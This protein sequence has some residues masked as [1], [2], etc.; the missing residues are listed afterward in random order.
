MGKLQNNPSIGWVHPKSTHVHPLGWGNKNIC[1]TFGV[2]E[3]LVSRVELDNI[4]WI[5][6]ILIYSSQHNL[7]KYY[8]E[9]V[10]SF[11]C[12]GPWWSMSKSITNNDYN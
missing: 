7:Y 6:A 1:N 4:F 8:E 11:V 10:V 2:L 9:Y 3:F 5:F 12:G